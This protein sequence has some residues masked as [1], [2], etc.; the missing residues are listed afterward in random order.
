MN[1][2]ECV[3]CDY[4]WSPRRDNYHYGLKPKTC[5]S[6]KSTRWDPAPKLPTTNRICQGICNMF[7][8][9]IQRLRRNKH[10]YHHSYDKRVVKA[11]RQ[12]QKYRKQDYYYCQRCEI[13][14]LKTLAF[15]TETFTVCPCCNGSVRLNTRYPEHEVKKVRY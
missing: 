13:Y 1:R 10:G 6:C 4:I 8:D 9:Q 15:R 5:P 3:I 7:L 14:M 11:L 12:I 2:Y